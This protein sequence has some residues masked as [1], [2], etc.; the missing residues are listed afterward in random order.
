MAQY[1]PGLT[2]K[3]SGKDATTRTPLDDVPV[4]VLEPNLMKAS[5]VTKNR[6]CVTLAENGPMRTLVADVY[7]CENERKSD[8]PPVPGK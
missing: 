7:A 5:V 4:T 8:A 2:E 1:W 6:A 3:Y